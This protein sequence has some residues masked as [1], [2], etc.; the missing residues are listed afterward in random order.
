MLI[1]GG[2]SDSSHADLIFIILNFDAPRWSWRLKLQVQILKINSNAKCFKGPVLYVY[3]LYICVQVSSFEGSVFMYVCM[4]FLCVFLYKAMSFLYSS[5]FP[6]IQ[7]R[8][9]FCW[10]CKI[11]ISDVYTVSI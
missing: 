9:L 10:D 6:L 1:R 4:Y 11:A 8:V 3:F 2:R 5:S 7:L